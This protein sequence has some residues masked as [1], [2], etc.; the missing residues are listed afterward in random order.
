M[1]TAIT[2]KTNDFYFGR[3]LDMECSFNE[4][5]CVTP[6]K[7]PF[8]FRNGRVV[9]EH[10]SMIGMA[11]VSEGY[12][13]YY[14]ATNEKGL[15]MA[16]L[17]FPDNAV[18]YSESEIKEN[19]A[20]FEFVPFVLSQCE[21]VDEALIKIEGIN[22]WNE[23]FSEELPLS[24]LHWILADKERAVTVESLKDGLKI[25]ENPVGVLTN[26]PP[27]DYHM[28]NIVN[29][30][31]LTP[32]QPEN[33]FSEVLDIKPYSLGMGAVGLPGDLS[34]ASRFVK[35]AF[36]KL[37]SVCGSTEA[38]SVSQFFHVLGSVEQQRGLNR[39]SGGKY[40]YTVYS[41]CCNA[42]KGIY[43][44]K[45]Y[46]NSRITAVDMHKTDLNSAELSVYPQVTGQQIM[47][48]N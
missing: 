33:R 9:R 28:H 38:E 25:Y 27:F 47:W 2:F 7:Y 23:S 8:V 37:N 35:A 31:N 40:E 46:E 12:P 22:L 1:C 48:G 10:Y 24:P 16:G 18:Y 42:E 14:E 39:M 44:Y 5:V 15:S 29:F 34:S 45:T 6:R 32:D 41:S 20:P 30:I 26:N 17:N 43:Y 36:T 19:V 3:N 11:A 13:L 4:A 21:S